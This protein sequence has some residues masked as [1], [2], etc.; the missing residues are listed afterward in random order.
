MRSPR[1][2]ALASLVLL[3]TAAVVTGQ[4]AI[5]ELRATAPPASGAVA[6]WVTDAG[7]P[8]KFNLTASPL[9]LTLGQSTALDV[10]GLDGTAPYTYVWKVPLGCVGSD[11]PS[12]TCKPNET[13]R[14]TVSVSITDSSVPNNRS[15]SASLSLVVNSPSSGSN[16]FTAGTL[17]LFSGVIGIVAAAVTAIVI[18]T[19]WRRRR[20]SAPLAPVPESPYVPPER[21]DPRP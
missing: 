6:P 15:G 19:F 5:S 18:V 21:D 2:I 12:L 3:C 14:F 4:G 8:L 17:F 11:S 10:T 9:S 16:F 7:P 1:A 20:R 13:G